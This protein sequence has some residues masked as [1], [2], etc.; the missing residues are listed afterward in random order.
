MVAGFRFVGQRRDDM[1]ALA[2]I[3]GEALQ[4]QFPPAEAPPDRAVGEDRRLHPLGR[5]RD[6]GQGQQAAAAAKAGFGSVEAKAM[7]AQH[8]ADQA[9]ADAKQDQHDRAADHGDRSDAP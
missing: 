4:L 1:V 8:G 9:G 3:L 2:A 7:F 6:V 5:D